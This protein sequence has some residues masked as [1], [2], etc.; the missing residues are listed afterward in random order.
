MWRG[1]GRLVAVVLVVVGQTGCTLPRDFAEELLPRV[2]DGVL[3]RVTAEP[4]EGFPTFI[5]PEML[6]GTSSPSPAATSTEEA[7]LTPTLLPSPSPAPAVS[8]AAILMVTP[9]IT[10]SPMLNTLERMQTV[11]PRMDPVRPYNPYTRMT[12][13]PIGPPG[14][15]G[16]RLAKYPAPSLTAGYPVP[17][18]VPTLTIT[19]T[20]P[21]AQVQAKM[22]DWERH[23]QGDPS[24]HY[25]EMWGTLLNEGTQTIS[26]VKLHFV[27]RDAGG[28]S[29]VADWTP[30]FVTLQPGATGAWREQIYTSR[31]GEVAGVELVLAEA[32]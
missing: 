5:V 13:H 2:I 27:L 9:S 4:M 16:T 14:A 18:P 17:M 21:S 1:W 12:V 19:G 22:L 3:K 10:A 20:T 24:L 26:L 28:E 7:T 8:V 25:V 31:A 23:T 6:M 32:Q 29:I 30:V 11:R 15:V